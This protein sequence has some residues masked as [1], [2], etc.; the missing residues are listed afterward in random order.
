MKKYVLLLLLFFTSSYFTIKAQEYYFSETPIEG[1][2]L[3]NFGNYYEDISTLLKNKYPDNIFT[4]ALYTKKDEI[5]LW[6]IEFAGVTYD[7][8]TLLF[9][10]D[11][12]LW[13]INFSQVYNI[14]HKIY[15]E[16]LYQTL[17]KRLSS[18]YGRGNIMIDE[19][20]DKAYAWA[21]RGNGSI[22]LH[23]TKSL[24]KGKEEMYY[25]DVEYYDNNSFNIINSREEEM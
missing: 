9:I 11:R 2:W 6:D 8:V 17:Y 16:Q 23:L 5:K 25:V 10:Y 3:F 24:S 20:E 21:D 13:S 22:I 19:L 1:A 4:S 12:F 7:F 14:E 15:A 18:K